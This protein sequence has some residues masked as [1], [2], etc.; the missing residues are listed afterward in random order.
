MYTHSKQ[1]SRLQT[2]IAYLACKMQVRHGSRSGYGSDSHQRVP[3]GCY[4][5]MTVG[6]ETT[7]RNYSCSA[8]SA[9]LASSRWG[10]W[11]VLMCINVS[12]KFSNDEKTNNTSYCCRYQ[13]RVHLYHMLWMFGS[14]NKAHLLTNS[15]AYY[16]RK[17]S[18]GLCLV[19]VKDY[20][21]LM[22]TK[23][24]ILVVKKTQVRMA[25]VIGEIL[26]K[27]CDKLTHAKAHWKVMHL[28]NHFLTIRSH[29]TSWA[30]YQIRK[31][32][33][34]RVSDPDIHHG[35]CVTYVPWCMPGSLTSGFLW[36]HRRES[37]PGACP[38]LGFAVSGKRPMYGS[39][40][41]SMNGTGHEIDFELCNMGIR[42]IQ[43]CQ[44]T[45]NKIDI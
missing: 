6:H 4:I 1:Q 16:H 31:I 40:S 9:Y 17:V 30:Y 35:T 12:C 33:P 5:F 44:H 29:S 26:A 24:R 27:R 43:T 15:S 10:C 20:Y 28:I 45:N 37:I 32:A 38:I 3:V 39:N 22:D 21:Y 23:Q 11:D 41:R 42:K 25:N 14:I 18:L 2:G 8:N 19:S 36:S 13:C 7:A 34:Q